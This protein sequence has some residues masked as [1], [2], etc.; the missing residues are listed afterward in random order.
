MIKTVKEN[1]LSDIVSFKTL[2]LRT[3]QESDERDHK[4]AEILHEQISSELMAVRLML[5][6]IRIEEN[7]RKLV[8]AELG[9]IA[10]RLKLLS[11]S[12]V[13]THLVELGVGEAIKKCCK[14]LSE[15]HDIVVRYTED[16]DGESPLPWAVQNSLYK[17][18]SE[19]LNGMIFNNRPEKILVNALNKNVGYSVR[20]E[21]DGKCLNGDVFDG[22]YP[23]YIKNVMGRIIQ[24]NARFNFDNDKNGNVVTIKIE[25]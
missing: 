23:N 4:L 22:N 18:V 7:E 19:V 1:V 17:V 20:I 25:K 13:P 3:I 5:K 16:G 10:S 24:L 6:R 9:K 12:I 15:R 2:Y 21:D 11:N 14:D 8:D